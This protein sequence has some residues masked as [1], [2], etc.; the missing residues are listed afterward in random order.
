MSLKCNQGFSECISNLA[1]IA[2]ETLFFLR[3]AIKVHNL[4]YLGYSVYAYQVCQNTSVC[5]SNF[6]NFELDKV[7]LLQVTPSK[8]YVE[9]NI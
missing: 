1:V 4:E 8:L 3:E 7:C 6:G 2:C 5:C 9:V